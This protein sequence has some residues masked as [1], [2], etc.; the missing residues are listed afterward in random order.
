LQEQELIASLKQGSEV[1]FKELVDVFKDRIYN[2]SL[3]F[4]QNE[5]DAEEVTQDVFIK[6]FEKI[7]GFRGD[8]KLSTWLYRIAVTES[9]EFLRKKKRKKRAGVLMSFFNKKEDEWHQPDFNHPGVAAENKETA[10][11]LFKA[12][13]QLPEQQQT[14]FLLKK[15]ENLS[16]TEIADVMNTSV[17]AVESLLQRAKTNLRKLLEEYYQKHFS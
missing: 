11:V 9:L 14:A 17:S 10:A 8:A 13:N 2:T 1:A 6:V 12:I 7:N 4:V 5:E 15:T 16:Q 3:G